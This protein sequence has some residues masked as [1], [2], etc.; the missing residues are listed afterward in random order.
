M[1]LP[2]DETSEQTITLMQNLAKVGLDIN[3]YTV[4]FNTTNSQRLDL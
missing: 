2:E 4:A 3:E 1:N